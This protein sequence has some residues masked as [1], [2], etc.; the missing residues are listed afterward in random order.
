MHSAPVPTN[1][2]FSNRPFRV[3]HFQATGSKA[4]A[5]AQNGRDAHAAGEGA[6]QR[7]VAGAEKRPQSVASEEPVA[8]SG[9][10]PAGREPKQLETAERPIQQT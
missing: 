2:R 4:G 6:G 5:G 7:P 8:K 10:K 9:A 1:A 3:K